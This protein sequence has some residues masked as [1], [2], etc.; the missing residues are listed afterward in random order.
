[1]ALAIFAVNKKS[2]TIDEFQALPSGLAILQSG[3]YRYLK[4]SPPLSPVL[5]AL[6]AWMANVSAGEAALEA[7]INSWLLG[8]RFA[9]EHPENYQNLF[10]SAR[11][12]SALALLAT[13]LLSWLIARRLYG[14]RGAFF[15]AVAAGFCP[16]LLA[17]GVLA[18]PD[19]FLALGFLFFFWFLEQYRIRGGAWESLGLGFS[20]AFAAST[21]F[22]G[23]LL[24]P[25]LPIVTFVFFG[26]KSFRGVFQA[27]FFGWLGIHLVYLFQGSFPPL[28][29]FSFSSSF[30]Q[31]V[32]ASLPS[33]LPVPLPFEF[34]RTLDQQLGEPAYLSYLLGSSQKEGF[35]SYYLVAFFVK[36][37]IA[38]IA[39]ALLASFSSR[40]LEA[41]EKPLL[42]ILVFFFLFFS[43]MRHKNIGLRYLLF[44]Y[45]L[46]AIWI[47]RLGRDRLPFAAREKWGFS[48]LAC[49][50]FLSAALAWPNYLAYFNTLSGGSAQGHRYLL[51]SNLDWGQDLIGLKEFMDRQGIPILSLAYAGRVRPEIYG[52]NYETF[53]DNPTQEFVA[54]SANLLWGRTYFVNGSS[55]WPKNS[56]AYA[57]FR[58]KEPVAVIG[59]SIYIYRR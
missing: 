19:I 29:E 15:T 25:L 20:L 3:E 56:E 57:P 55:Y 58:E 47:G 42:L 21:K 48:L 12:A 43:L 31:A 32:Q 28:G 6:P 5:Q 49:G 37:P 10:M 51:D 16:M 9:K 36:T 38:F 45:P 27:W 7:E 2:V 39:L 33:A 53:R 11:A 22:T 17:H 50:A 13:L 26:I 59:H 8:H 44:L 4:G 40:K 52:I 14:S 30:F 23:L 54:I 34:L 46:L 18:T 24:F 1:V 41:K 35:F